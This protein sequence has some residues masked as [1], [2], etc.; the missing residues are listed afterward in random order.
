MFFSGPFT[1]LSQLRMNY[2]M[3]TMDGSRLVT[4]RT[5]GMC[6]GGGVGRVMTRYELIQVRFENH[7]SCHVMYQVS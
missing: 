2:A 1:T 3:S 4:F 5:H 6:W 7:G